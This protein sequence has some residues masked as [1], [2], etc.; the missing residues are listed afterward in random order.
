MM[1]R[2][3]ECEIVRNDLTIE[4]VG[5]DDIEIEVRFRNVSQIQAFKIIEGYKE[6]HLVSFTWE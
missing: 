3:I 5:E 1:P 4:Y 6:Q 2:R